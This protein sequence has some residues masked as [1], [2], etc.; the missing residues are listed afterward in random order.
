MTSHG[1]SKKLIDCFF[2]ATDKIA[3]QWVPIALCSIEQEHNIFKK[4][5]LEI[6]CNEKV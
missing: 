5:Y 4:I 6:K 2:L 1:F 3:E